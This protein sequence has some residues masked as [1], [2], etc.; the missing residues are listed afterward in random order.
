MNGT[1]S[2]A[3]AVNGTHS[4][5]RPVCNRPAGSV[6][7]NGVP[8]NDLSSGPPLVNGAANGDFIGNGTHDH[9]LT[10]TNGT[11]PHEL[12]A[13]L[14][15]QALDGD[16]KVSFPEDSTPQHR[17]FPLSARQEKQ[18][19]RRIS[20]LIGYIKSLNVSHD[21][22]FL[23]DLSYTLCNRREHFPYR[24]VCTASTKEEL[25]RK[26]EE[27]TV[28]GRTVQQ[29]TVGF[30]FTGQGTQWQ[31][32]GKDLLVYEEFASSIRDADAFLQKL[33]ADWS[34]KGTR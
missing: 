19:K 20:D 3:S 17:F 34:L 28:T 27:A 2:A 25:A 26:L 29:P 16:S 18:L 21:E 30:V 9:T 15:S 13:T 14:D 6:S 1:T 11:Q 31:G 8:H 4:E 23:A 5:D 33:G 10:T 22:Q 32:M 12:S 24:F 7:T